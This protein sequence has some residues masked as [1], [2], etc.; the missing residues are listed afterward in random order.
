MTPIKCGRVTGLLLVACAAVGAAHMLITCVPSQSRDQVIKGWD[1]GIAGMWC[2]LDITC[3][4][5][6]VQPVQRI[7][8][9]RLT[10]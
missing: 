6:V 4:P 10:V 3:H 7:L 2:V 9:R 5:L 1:Q 8:R